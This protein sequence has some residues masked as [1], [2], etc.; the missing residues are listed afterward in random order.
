MERLVLISIGYFT[1]SIPIPI[2]ILVSM[3]EIHRYRYQY[4]VSEAKVSVNDT[5]TDSIAHLCYVVADTQ[6]NPKWYDTSYLEYRLILYDFLK[7]FK[8]QTSIF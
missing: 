7:K 5:D 8:I 3:V 1:P 2:P 4:L 6:S